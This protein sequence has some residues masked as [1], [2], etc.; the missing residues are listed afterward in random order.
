MDKYYVYL[1]RTTDDDKVFYVGSGCG[2]RM[3]AKNGRSI[4]WNNLVKDRQWYSTV[5]KQDM[6]RSEA[7]ELELTLIKHYV[8]EGNVRE[9]SIESKDFDNDLE[10][11]LSTF[12]YSEISPSGLIYKQDSR[13]KGRG[14]KLKGETVGSIKNGRYRISV[15]NK[16]RLTYR[17]VWLLCTGEDPVDFIIDHIDGNTLNNNISNLR[18]VTQAVNSKNLKMRIDNKTGHTNISYRNGYYSVS[19]VLFGKDVRKSFSVLKYGKEVALALAIEYKRRMFNAALRSGED[20]TERHIGGYEK[21]S[22]LFDQ[23]AESISKILAEPSL[24]SNNKSGIP[25]ISYL[26]K[27]GK[28]TVVAQKTIS[29]KIM[30]KKMSVDKHGLDVVIKELTTWLEQLT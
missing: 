2:K 10:Y 23:S 27:N 13:V 7:R 26:V 29:G 30:N 3:V 24:N 16:R 20:Y 9:T 11:I 6:P 14:I 17:I 28:T 21:P 19:L 15:N 8:P 4:P 18:K 5:V 12:E 1:H 25:N 22:V